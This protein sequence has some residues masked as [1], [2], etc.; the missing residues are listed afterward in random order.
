MSIIYSMNKS[1]QEQVTLIC[2]S[3]LVD[4]VSSYSDLLDR[5]S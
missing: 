2:D 3:F 1:I 5:D 4:Y